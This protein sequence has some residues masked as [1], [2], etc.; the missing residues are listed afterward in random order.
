MD[1]WSGWGVMVVVEFVAGKAGG[2][3][4]GG[5]KG[6]VGVG[7]LRMGGVSHVLRI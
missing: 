1:G 5:G 4:K 6:G 7:C 2:R 3:E